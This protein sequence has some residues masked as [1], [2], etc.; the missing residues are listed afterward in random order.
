MA[1]SR[2]SNS[3]SHHQSSTQP[4]YNIDD[5]KIEYHKAAGIDAQVY[6]F[7]N[8]T[9]RTPG[10]DPDPSSKPW[11]PFVS[12]ADFEFAELAHEAH[13]NKGQITR[14]LQLIKKITSHEDTFTFRNSEDVD[15]AWDKAKL[16]YPT[17]SKSTFCVDYKGEPQQF[18]LHSRSLWDWILQQ[19]KDPQLAHQFHWN[20]QQLS[21]FDGKSWVRFFDEPWTAMKFAQVQTEIMKINPRGK[22]IAIIIWADT[23]KLSTFGGQKGHFIVARIGNL[24]SDIRNSAA[25]GGGRIVGFVPIVVE[26]PNERKKT[27]FVNFKNAVYH[28]AFRL[29]LEKIA[30]LSQVGYEV[31]CGDGISRLL[32]PYIHIISAD[33]EEHCRFPLNRGLGGLAPC[34]VCVIPSGTLSNLKQRHDYRSEAQAMEIFCSDGVASIKDEK[35]KQI[36][37][38]NVYNAFWDIANTDVHQ[39][40]S[41][42]RLHA[43]IIGL[44]KQHL[45]EELKRVINS[46]GR[47][48][49]VEFENLVKDFPRWPKLAHFSNGVLNLDY[50]DGNKWE[51]VS[52]IVLPVAYQVLVKPEH[53]GA[54]A[55]AL[56]LLRVTRR[57]I[58]LNLFLSFT[59]QTEKTIAAYERTLNRFHDALELYKVECELSGAEF[60]KDWDGII[61]VHSQTHAANDIRLKG[62]INNMDTKQNEKLNGAMRDAYHR[63]TNFRDIEAQL[64]QLEDR[65]MV[66]GTIRGYIDTLDDFLDEDDDET[67]GLRKG[68]KKESWDFE[69]IYLGSRQNAV[70]LS[71][72]V[73]KGC[74]DLA[75]TDFSKKLS[76]CINDILIQEHLNLCVEQGTLAGVPLPPFS[77]VKDS[78]LITECRYIKVN[79]ESK[80]TWRMNTD[81]LRCSPLF[82]GSPRYDSAIMLWRGEDGETQ[83]ICRLIRAFTYEVDGRKYGLALVQPFDEQVQLRAEDRELGICR[84]RA[85]KRRDSVVVPIRAIIRGAVTVEDRSTNFDE[86]MVVDSL[87][88]DMF[89]RLMPLFPERDTDMDM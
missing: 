66:S 32:F 71:S 72:F 61:K 56:A 23:S 19:V 11:S 29:F 74:E 8:V 16:R 21:K 46:L 73:I 62:T 58:E 69:H 9:R 67:E 28:T 38:R 41:F 82:Y 5:I 76:E 45:F 43:Y 75:F 49:Q 52:K 48:V 34:P 2:D 88:E 18:T 47:P 50:S 22:P 27:G 25:L 84:V 86:Y 77:V 51:D 89:L 7:E 14:L 63:Q 78:D 15:K 85:R 30:H 3:T 13:L 26:D 42:D 39:A 87:D 80:V 83:S 53:E 1:S 33:Y 60:V 12:R 54:S 10:V 31:V 35:M 81:R 65:S 36:G 68:K 4:E 44:W 6:E 55:V 24:P 20:A 79:F 17:F 70:T 57:W 40:I 64:G 37:L 59:V